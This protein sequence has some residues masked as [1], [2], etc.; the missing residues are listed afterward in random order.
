MRTAKDNRRTQEKPKP[1]TDHFE[2]GARAVHLGV[3]ALGACPDAVL[4]D[5]TDDIKKGTVPAAWE[6]SSPR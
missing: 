3:A 2:G 6:Q 1:S 5:E 4:L